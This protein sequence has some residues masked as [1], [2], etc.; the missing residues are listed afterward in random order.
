LDVGA[1]IG[2]TLLFFLQ[3]NAK[4][5]DCYEPIKENLKILNQN[6]REEIKSKKV[7]IY[8]F[9]VCDKTGKIS[10]KVDKSSI[11]QRDFGNKK[12]RGKTKIKLNCISWKKVLSSEEFDIAKIDCEG[13]EIHLKDCS[14]E[15]LRRIPNWVIEAHSKK[16]EKILLEKFKEANFH[17]IKKEKLNS[18]TSILT[19]KR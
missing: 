18:Q 8:P 4:E 13:G 7:K 17:L 12:T 6:F 14:R 11:G 16:I 5:V 15:E 3:K 9:A 2:D 19:F 10:I 1:Y